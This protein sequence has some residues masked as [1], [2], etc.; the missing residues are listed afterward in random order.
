MKLTKVLNFKLNILFVINFIFILAISSI[1]LAEGEW[2]IAGHLR[3]KRGPICNHSVAWQIG[4]PD[5]WETTTGP[6]GGYSTYDWWGFG[7]NNTVSVFPRLYNDAVWC[8]PSYGFLPGTQTAGSIVQCNFF[9]QFGVEVVNDP[10]ND[11]GNNEYGDPINTYNGSLRVTA[12][13]INIP[14]KLP[15]KFVRTYKSS[16][17]P[18]ENPEIEVSALDYFNKQFESGLGYEHWAIAVYCPLGRGWTHTYHIYLAEDSESN[19]EN[20]LLFLDDG[21]SWKFVK[22]GSSYISPKGFQAVLSEYENSYEVEMDNG[23]KYIFNKTVSM[24]KTHKLLQI[25][26]RNNDSLTFAYEDSENPEYATKITQSGTNLEIRISYVDGKMATITYPDTNGAYTKQLNYSY[27]NDDLEGV[28]G[29][30]NYNASYSYISH[31]LVSKSDCHCPKGYMEGQYIY[32]SYFRVISATDGRGNETTFE[33]NP[34]STIIRVN[35]KIVQTDTYNDYGFITS[36]ADGKGY[37]AVYEWDLNAYQIVCVTDKYGKRTEYT[38]NNAGDVH[39]VIQKDPFDYARIVS[40]I[41]YLYENASFPDLVTKMKNRLT[42][43]DLITSY[44]YDTKGNLTQITNPDGSEIKYAYGTNSNLITLTDGNQKVTEFS[45]H[46]MFGNIGSI[47]IPIESGRYS[48]T[49]YAYD[50]IGRVKTRTDPGNTGI[51]MYYYDDSDK[52]TQITYPDGK[53]ESYNYSDNVSH[54]NLA[55]YT[56]RNGNTTIYTYDE[57]DNVISETAANISQTLFEYDATGFRTKTTQVR[58]EGNIVTEYTPDDSGLLWKI[59]DKVHPITEY[60]YY[61]NGKLQSSKNWSGGKKIEYLYDA[62]ERLD[63]IVYNDIVHILT[64]TYSLNSSQYGG[65]S[66]NPAT[67]VYN[68][69][70]VM[71]H[72]TYEYDDMARNTK[73]VE[74]ERG[75]TAEYEYDNNGNRTKMTLSGNI[76]GSTAKVWNY[77]Y[78]DCNWLKKVTDP[79][80]KSTTYEYNNA[81]LMTKITYPN[82]VV[83][84]YTYDSINQRLKSIVWKDKRGKMLQKFS[85]AQYDGVGNITQMKE[86]TGTNDYTYDKLYQLTKVDYPTGR[87]SSAKGYESFAY[88]KAGNRTVLNTNI[89]GRPAVMNYTY[90]LA[91]ELITAGNAGY[92]YDGNGNTSQKIENSQT[93]TYSYDWNNML[94]GID[95]PESQPDMSFKYDGGGRRIEKTDSRGTTKYYWDNIDVVMETDGSNSITAIYTHGNMLISKEHITGINNKHKYYYLYDHLGNT[96]AKTDEYGNLVNVYYYDVFGKCWNVTS[97]SLNNNQYIGGYGITFDEDSG[98]YYMKARYYNSEIGRFMSRDMLC[99]NNKF[100]F[101]KYVVDITKPCSV[102]NCYFYCANDPVNYID[103]LGLCE[104]SFYQKLGKGYYY[105]TYAGLESTKW[106][107]DRIAAGEWL[108]N[109]PLGFALLWTPETYKIT[110]LTLVSASL[111]IG[112]ASRGLTRI[113]FHG[114]H[115]G[116]VIPHIQ[117]IKGPGYGK[118]LWRFPPH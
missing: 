43:P 13:D 2:Y 112:P 30:G 72:N 84:I 85:Y 113:E 61:P 51:F 104:E 10:F 102:I 108:W 25:Q 4:T 15:L 81:G 98:L 111:A 48:E 22:S 107:A 35:N 16:Y 50:I 86:L 5:V 96:R 36:I 71:Y 88:D 41:E 62:L 55:R 99:F 110:A 53:Q 75:F 54:G 11:Y 6:T 32:D 1:V 39:T 67:M 45:N 68:A 14:G 77:E 59:D 38:Y 46:D 78:Y 40:D 87:S 57:C 97:D 92:G 79:D 70:D 3:S 109:V 23:L 89:A 27:S 103:P 100:N 28:T 24:F 47:R 33:Y 94:V 19:Y 29:P 7:Q 66:D 118:T 42:E 116:R 69:G 82:S 115:G 74:T 20:L 21:R 65:G 90:N 52:I 76:I 37:V 8:P 60:T 18:S 9:A 58:D 114:T 80:S 17:I 93:T 34:A 73:I 44:V 56:D 64:L 26:N 31:K 12:V 117:A 83:G 91:N 101:Y 106:Y 105:G 49:V 63:T 95:S